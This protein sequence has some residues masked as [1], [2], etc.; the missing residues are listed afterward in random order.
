MN[1]TKKVDISCKI[2]Q[3]TLTIVFLAISITIS[4]EVWEQYA[5]KAT[6]FKQSEAD[7]TKLESVTV[8]FGFWPLKNSDY[9]EDVPH[10]TYDQWMLDKDFTVSYGVMTNRKIQEVTVLKENS[11]VDHVMHSSIGTVKLEPLITISGTYYKVTANIIDVKLPNYAFIQIDFNE[12]ITWNDVPFTEVYMSI[13]ENSFG[14]TM[15]DW[16]DGEYLYFS[17]IRGYNAYKVQPHKV[18]KFKSKSNCQDQAFYKCFGAKLSKQDYSQC[19]RKCLAVSTMTSNNSSLCQTQQ[20]FQCAF[21][22]AQ[23]LKEDYSEER[24]LPSCTQ[25]NLKLLNK[26][27]EGRKDHQVTIA[28]NIPNTKMKVEEEYLI[29][30]FVSMLGSIGG[31]LGMCTGFSCIGILSFILRFLQTLIGKKYAKKSIAVQVGLNK[32]V[33][34]RRSVSIGSQMFK[35]KMIKVNEIN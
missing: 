17:K 11:I 24:C 25:V 7:I 13:E 10:Q 5:S 26:H 16:L 31:T 22:I 21:D 4:K 12:N 3:A 9:S 23:T 29:R 8:V 20:E 27:N 28:Y 33:P 18:K 34:R 32:E 15:N 19:P 6:S 14:V 30:D 35:S 1:F 2:V